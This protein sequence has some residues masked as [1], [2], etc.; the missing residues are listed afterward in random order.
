MNCQPYIKASLVDKGYEPNTVSL[1]TIKQKVLRTECAFA[2]NAKDPNVL[3]ALNPTLAAGYATRS[4]RPPRREPRLPRTSYQFK[5][6]TLQAHSVSEP[7]RDRTRQPNTGNSRPPRRSEQMSRKSVDAIKCLHDNNKCFECEDT[8]HMAKDCPKH[9][10]LPFKPSRGGPSSLQAH[11]VG[12]STT[13]IHAAAIEEGITCG[14]YGMAVC[15]PEIS[16]LDAMKRLV[17]AERTLASHWM[18]I[19]KFRS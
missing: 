1:D 3:L 7:S 19:L 6:P 17:V 11:A 4:S 18:A 16:E 13:D 12:I 5:T 9:H 15:I 14:L 2:E 8:R 10:H